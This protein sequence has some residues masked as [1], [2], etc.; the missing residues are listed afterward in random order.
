M[1]DYLRFD[2]KLPELDTEE[3]QE[4]LKKQLALLELALARLSDSDRVST[5]I[6]QKVVSV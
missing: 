5:D 4:Q 2:S 3:A 6:Y 1:P